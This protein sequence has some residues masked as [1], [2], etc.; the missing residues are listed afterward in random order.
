MTLPNIVS[1]LPGALIILGYLSLLLL[2]ENLFSR[3]AEYSVVAL[4][5]G[6]S[7][8][9]YT[10]DAVKRAWTPLV[11]GDWTMIIPIALGL[12]MYVQF[13]KKYRWVIRWP[14]AV[15]SSTALMLNATARPIANFVLQLRALAIPLISGSG[16]DIFNGLI[17]LIACLTVMS[18]FTFT[19]EHTGPLAIS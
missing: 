1:Y 14:L 7:A 6:W 18:Y 17:A 5:V 3:W 16:M 4:A 11:G 8:V 9:Y 13:S 2:K 15:V 10:Y 12:L 19:R